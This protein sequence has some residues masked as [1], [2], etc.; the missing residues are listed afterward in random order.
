MWTNIELR[1]GINI[2]SE[3]MNQLHYL[4]Q[5]I[6]AKEERYPPVNPSKAPPVQYTQSQWKRTGHRRSTP[7]GW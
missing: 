4:G 5:Y 3:P 2:N 7:L 6:I 1:F